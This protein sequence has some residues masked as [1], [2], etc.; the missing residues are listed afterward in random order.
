MS[1][2]RFLPL[3]LSP[4]QAVNT[5][6]AFDILPVRASCQLS[7]VLITVLQF[8]QSVPSRI[9][10][11]RSTLTLLLAAAERSGFKLKRHALFIQKP[12]MQSLRREFKLVR[13][14]HFMF[15]SQYQYMR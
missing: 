6:S 8:F 14:Q 13:I 1:L 2:F 11:S 12:R 3:L 15:D 7:G 9:Y 5:D 4:T 10:R